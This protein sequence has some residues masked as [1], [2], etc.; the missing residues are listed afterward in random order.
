MT[1][2][3]PIRVLLA[4]CALI[5]STCVTWNNKDVKTLTDALPE[6]KAVLSLVKNDGQVVEFS[7]TNPGRVRGYTVVGVARN[8]EMREIEIAGP[9]SS[10]QQDEKGRVSAVTDGTEKNWVVGA[11]IKVGEDRMTILGT[12]S[13]Q[14]TIPL[15][16]VSS[17]RI[18]QDNALL[19]AAIL[20][21]AIV[22]LPLI[23]LVI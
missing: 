15:S 19:I 7:K 2:R 6:D 11:V 9:F 23:A 4:A 8:A 16:E 21:G 14:L 10:I 13:N 20:L 17:L 12:E 1:E 5:L 22:A 3:R 18:R